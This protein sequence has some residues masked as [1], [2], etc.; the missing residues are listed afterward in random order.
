VSGLALLER[1]LT[2]QGEHAE[3]EQALRE[4]LKLLEQYPAHSA[5][6]DCRRQELVSVS[7]P[8]RDIQGDENEYIFRV[9]HI[10]ALFSSKK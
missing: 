8:R 5:R 6:M 10:S 2:R 7:L 4:G 1:E 9:V 3:A